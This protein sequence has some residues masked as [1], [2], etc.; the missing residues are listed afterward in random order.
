VNNY[1]FIRFKLLSDGFFIG[2]EIRH[3]TFG[4][5]GMI[6]DR[7]KFVRFAP[8]ELLGETTKVR[9]RITR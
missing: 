8:T 7:S 2:D 9:D 1:Q 3:A 5:I 6:Y 4:L